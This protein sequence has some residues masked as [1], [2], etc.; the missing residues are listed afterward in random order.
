MKT[1]ELK[2]GCRI[3]L[4]CG[5]YATL[6]DN[7]KGNTRLADVEGIYREIGS[8]Y[9]H[10]I[11]AYQDANGQWHNDIELTPSQIKCQKMAALI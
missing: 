8:I 9:S 5:W 1:N 6:M 3:R 4:R 2:K 10:D 7:M 11:A